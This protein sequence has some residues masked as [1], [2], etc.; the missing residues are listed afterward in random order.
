VAEAGFRAGAERAER[1]GVLPGAPVVRAALLLVE[2]AA[3]RE[4]R[5]EVGRREPF[6][7]SEGGGGARRAGRR[8]DRDPVAERAERLVVGQGFDAGHL[9]A[10]LAAVEAA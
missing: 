6:C 3:G 2:E 9:Q 4:F 5:G 8:T 1:G 10:L 7:R